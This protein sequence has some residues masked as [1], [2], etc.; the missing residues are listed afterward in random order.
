MAELITIA[1]PY[2]EAAF[3]AAK[4][5]NAVADWSGQL[6]KLAM[7]A[8]DETLQTFEKSSEAT[9]DKVLEVIVGAMGSDLMNPVHNL[10]KVMAENKRLSALADVAEMFQQLQA[11]D[12][13]RVRATVISAKTTTVEQQ[14]KLSAALNAKFDADVEITYEEDPSLLA[15]IKIKVGDWVVDGSA[16]SQLNKLG[17]AIAQ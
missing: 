10:L 7:I 16:Q 8:Q 6:Q 14:S 12:E 15:G 9:T 17:A 1:R 2:A 4:E 5:D 3:A 11:D 13:K